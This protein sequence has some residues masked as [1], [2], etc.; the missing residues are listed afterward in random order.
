MDTKA[1]IRILQNN[2]D[3]IDWEVLSE[4][5]LAITFLEAN[6]KKIYWRNLTLNSAD[7]HLLE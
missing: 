5:P 7:I 4:N 1:Y 2:I 6:L 3:K